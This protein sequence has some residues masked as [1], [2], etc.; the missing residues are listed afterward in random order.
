MKIIA[1]ANNKGGVGKSTVN[2]IL[3]EYFSSILKKRTLAIDLDP[4]C[5]FSRR[6][7]QM[8]IDP[9]DPEG[10][11]PPINP[12]YDPN[13]PD[14]K[15]WDGRS[16]IADI[17]FGKLLYPYPTKVP[18]LEL[19]P[20]HSNKLKEI[21]LVRKSE[22]V[23]KVQSHLDYFL[24]LP[25]VR[26]AYDVVV[27]DTAPSKGPLTI[28]AI[29][30][31]THMLI[32]SPMEPQP[33]EGVFGMLQLWKQESLRR[34]ASDPLK[35]LGILPN[36]FRSNLRLHSDLLAQLQNS[37]SVSEYILPMKLGQRA[38]FA[39]VDAVGANPAAIFDL[40]DSNP[41]KQEALAMCEYI[42]ERVF[43]KEI[44]YV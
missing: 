38:V 7:I 43:E 39:E 11:L 20:G 21:E 35:L 33:I 10:V 41:A 29:R 4:Q 32:P 24:H 19:A 23:E 44:S 40:P 34:K 2:R 5:N 36:M 6:F 3:A 27:I 31:A 28:C 8:E 25:D 13:D 30:S 17:F 14:Y 16:S 12:I 26:A 9:V 1:A 22:I 42:S 37:K 15:D 18:N